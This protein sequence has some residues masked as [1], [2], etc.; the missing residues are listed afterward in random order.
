MIRALLLVLLMTV[1]SVVLAQTEQP[2]DRDANR[3]WFQ[4]LP[5]GRRKLLMRRLRVY[6]S[7][8]K[9][10]RQKIR[11]RVKQDKPALTDS[12]RKAMASLSRV[13]YLQR[14][15]L[16]TIASELDGIKRFRKD[17]YRKA[18]NA[19]AVE[20]PRALMRLIH[21][22]RLMFYA[23]MLPK[24]RHDELRP[25]APDERIKKLTQWY[26]DDREAR[27]EALAKMHPRIKDLRAN[28]ANG[29]DSAKRELKH[30]QRDLIVLD[31]LLS[32]LP[33][34]R[35]E[36]VMAKLQNI[37]TK[38]AG[39]VLRKELTRFHRN[40][41]SRGPRPDREDRPPFGR[42]GDK[43]PPPDGRR[44]RKDRPHNREGGRPRR[45]N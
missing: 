20:R 14:V 40:M 43:A 24:E 37:D 19:P 6:R 8:P 39:R 23:R 17:A 29:D 4:N 42:H 15:R 32:R 22:Q 5:E 31:R 34:D 28:A 11:E 21:E 16:A 38:E 1:P 10:M 9:E 3:E 45:G 13:S 26:R 30:I 18:M 27:V 12:E 41:K 35:R 44:D 36:A 33:S 7:L 2:T 25:L